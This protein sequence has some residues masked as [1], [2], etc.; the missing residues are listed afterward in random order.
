M[1]SNLEN[2]F[3][4]ELNF[5]ISD[6]YYS[7]IGVLALLILLI[8]N[9]DILFRLYDGF[10][11]KAWK[12]YRK[13]LLTVLVYYITDII[14]G[15]LEANKLSVLLFADTTMYFFAMAAG[16]LLWT[17]YI[18]TY[19]EEKNL[20]GQILL[21]SGRILAALVS[22]F[23]TI[24]IFTS[25]FFTVTGNCEYHALG[26]RYIVLIAQILLL[27]LISVY[28]FSSIARR[29]VDTAKVRKYRTLGMFGFIM[30]VFLTAQL[31]F[32][33]YPLYAIAYMLGTCLLR[34]FVVGDEKEEYRS[35]VEEATRITEL[36]QSIT[37]LMDNMPALSFSKDAETGVY[38]ACN[39]A[40]AEYAHKPNPEGVVGLTDAEIFD[41]ATAKH[42]AE[43]DRIALELD[44]PHIF[45]EDVPD[46]AGIQRQFQTTKLKFI[47]TAG[48][49]CI[50]GMCQDV[51]GIERIRRAEERMEEQQVAFGRIS[52]LS[53]DYI[54][55]HVVDPESEHY[56]IYSATAGFRSFGLPKEGTDFFNTTREMS[57][58]L[59]HPEDLEFFLHSFTR[60]NVL[61]E[62]ERNGI[63]ALT[64]RLLIYEKPVYI[65]LKCAM[66]DEKEGRRL[67][68]G[69][70]D[71]DTQV[72]QEQE[73]A[74]QLA[75]AQNQAMIDALTGIR[76]K[77]A[78]LNAEEK[79]DKLIETKTQP[80]FAVVILDVND[81][82][83]INDTSGHQAGD[84]Y[85][86]DACR[87]V[88]QTF[89]H[90]PV[91]R[92]GG[93]EFAV[94]SQGQDYE[95]IEELTA[96]I[97]AHNEQA[98]R[99]GGIVI[100]CGMARYDD[101][102]SVASVFRRADTVMYEDKNRLKELSKIQETEV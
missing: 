67:I 5:K 91:F 98:L 26:A 58:S 72:R 74:K 31:W 37:S 22:V 97:A 12:V 46:A 43:D 96:I 64:Y 28:A 86:R 84:Q 17:Q 87:L 2:V 29:R 27:I 63:F 69:I 73:Y 36:K 30:A 79:I 89:K 16:V 35:R 56:S 88:C 1:F 61:A 59:V 3:K 78:Y 45:F 34:A 57:R 20:F 71:V 70:N 52:A 15:I 99:E 66:V 85:L 9:R 21:H 101:D 92:I 32:P 77:Y 13:F 40:F 39:Q 24:N 14:W 68:V 81:L 83:T 23:V 47:D 82:K 6:L 19:L 54:S 33:Y 93:D 8:E 76:N 100:A 50:L 4:A 102:T 38:L 18:V 75:Q 7:A 60:E 95:H 55:V 11:T 90:S 62:I 80:E 41:E 65:R 53:G 44:R 49:M 94:I 51:T 42:F 48:R 10:N 25:I